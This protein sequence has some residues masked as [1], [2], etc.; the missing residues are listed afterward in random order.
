MTQAKTSASADEFIALAIQTGALQFGEF[1][2]K[3]GRL[4]PYFFNSNAFYTAGSIRKL[5]RFY[6]DAIGDFACDSLFGPAYKGIPLVGA[7]G[8][9]FDDSRAD[10]KLC[11]N[12]KEAKTHGDQGRLAGAPVEGRV[13]IIDDVITAGTAVREAVALIT[14][15]GATAAGVAV[16]FDRCEKGPGGRS[17]LRELEDELQLPVFCIATFHT[18]H[19]HL[20]DNPDQA[21]ALKAIEAYRTQWGVD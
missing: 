19:A 15:T 1:T 10:C 16:C 14:E 13:L 9:A 7:V 18:L 11:Y 17:A 3:S 8:A 5:A 12:R 2:L 6:V 4:S 21:A 20:R